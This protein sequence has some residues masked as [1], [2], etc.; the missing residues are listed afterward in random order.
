MLILFAFKAPS[1]PPNN[2]TAQSNGTSVI[3]VAWEPIDQMFLHG[4]LRGYK[5]RYKEHAKM[6]SADW[7]TKTISHNTLRTNVTGLKAGRKYE[8]QVSAFTIKD[9]VWSK[10]IKATTQQN[11]LLLFKD[12]S[13]FASMR[14]TLK[15]TRPKRSENKCFWNIFRPAGEVESR[16][17]MPSCIR[18]LELSAKQ[19]RR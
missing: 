17:E 8:L 6:Y 9:G 18:R 3:Y 15:I 16:L 10:R 19:S 1:R 11:F 13:L 5:V 4:I 12:V 7:F 2:V 14:V